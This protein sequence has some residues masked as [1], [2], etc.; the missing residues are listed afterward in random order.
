M[1][2][3]LQRIEKSPRG[4]QAG[5]HTRQGWLS[6]RLVARILPDGSFIRVDDDERADV[7]TYTKRGQ[8]L[9]MTFEPGYYLHEDGTVSPNEYDYPVMT[10]PFSYSVVA[11]TLRLTFLRTRGRH[12][13]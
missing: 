1:A 3:P 12:Q 10:F 11:D 2:C 13:R 7:G 5:S 4:L 9:W 6:A 8:R